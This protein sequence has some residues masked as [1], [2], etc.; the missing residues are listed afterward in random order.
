MKTNLWNG[1]FTLS[2]TNR[3]KILIT[4]IDQADFYRQLTDFFGEDAKATMFV[5]SNV[6]VVKANNKKLGTFKRLV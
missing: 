5:L 4:A 6:G 2:K 3:T 1:Q